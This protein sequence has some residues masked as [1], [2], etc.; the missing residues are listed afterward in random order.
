MTPDDRLDAALPTALALAG[1][2]RHSV[3]ETHAIL[4][5][6][7]HDDL[8]AVAVALAILVPDDRTV[9]DLTAWT[10]GTPRE[11]VFTAAARI[12]YERRADLLTGIH[13]TAHGAALTKPRST[14]RKDTDAA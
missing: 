8:L 4:T 10:H 5:R 7:N 11:P 2:V 9:A 6:L 3:D 13:G 14:K 1:A 12:E